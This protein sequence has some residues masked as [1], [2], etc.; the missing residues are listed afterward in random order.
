LDGDDNDND[1]VFNDA[2]ADGD[3]NDDDND[4]VDDAGIVIAPLLPLLVMLLL[5]L[6]DESLNPGGADRPCP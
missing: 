3:V 2:A 1:K 6:F 5:P 4:T